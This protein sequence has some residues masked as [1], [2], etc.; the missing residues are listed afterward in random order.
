[1]ELVRV[2]NLCGTFCFSMQFVVFMDLVG[3]ATLPV[4]ICLTLALIIN[5]IITPPTDFET[6]IPLLLLASVL[7]LPAV[8]II[9]TTGKFIYVAW[10]FAYL[11]ALPI[12]NFVLPV[13]SFWHFDDFSWGE[14][15]F[16]SQSTPVKLRKDC[17]NGLMTIASLPALVTFLF[18]GKSREK[19]KELAMT[20]TR[21]HLSLL[22]LSA[23]G[24]IGSG[25]DYVVSSARNADR[26]ILNDSRGPSTEAIPVDSTSTEHVFILIPTATSHPAEVAPNMRPQIRVPCSLQRMIRLVFTSPFD[27]CMRRHL[28]RDD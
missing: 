16:V 24:K 18:L 26:R 12:W 3:T 14:T 17:Y 1:M 13:Y 22:S 23:D 21:V 2:R 6:A 11:C 8:L 4:A 10:M 25:L 7:G 15:R 9:I 28:H 19:Q 5:S 27:I 20:T